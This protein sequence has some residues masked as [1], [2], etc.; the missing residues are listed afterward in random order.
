MQKAIVVFMA[1]SVLSLFQGA[2]A[3]MQI[4][5]SGG[6]AIMYLTQDRRVSIGTTAPPVSGTVLDV[7][8]V[9][10]VDGLRVATSTAGQALVATGTNGTAAWGTVGSVGVTDNSLVA[11]DL[12]VNVVSSVEGVDND[13]GNIDLVPSGVVSISGNNPGNTITI[14]TAPVTFQQNFQPGN[15]TWDLVGVQPWTQLPSISYTVT[16]A[17]FYLILMDI[18]LGLVATATDW[19]QCGATIAI[20]GTLQFGEATATLS[21][22][23]QMVRNSASQNYLKQLAVGDVVTIWAKNDYPGT[24]QI[25]RTHTTLTLVQLY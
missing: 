6:L 16:K 2:F 4:K 24:V 25:Y 7:D 14:G 11:G 12:L 9:T 3:Q 8:G 10:K 18:D 22:G 19:A 21:A 17:G 5:N 20:N 15:I 13:G 23:T 1:G